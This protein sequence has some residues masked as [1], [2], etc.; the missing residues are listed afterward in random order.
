[1]PSSAA[2][3]PSR[4]RVS[5]VDLYVLRGRGPTLECLVLRRASG[6]RCTGAWEVVHGHIESGERPAAAARREM[7]EE[8]GLAPSRF[9]NV[10]RVEAFYQHG[11]DEVA[12]VPVFAAFV[13]DD[14]EPVLGSEHD[15]AEWLAPEAAVARLAWPREARALADVVRLLG[16]GDAGPLGDVLEISPPA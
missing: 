4:A 2:A 8:T 12:F 16:P 3:D 11:I 7:L 1:M 13:G 9:F 5:L 15:A 10:S 6:T 14:A